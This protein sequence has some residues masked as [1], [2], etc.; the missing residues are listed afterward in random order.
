MSMRKAISFKGVIVGAIVDVVGTHIALYA[1]LA[2][3]IIRHQL[4]TLPPAEQNGELQHLYGDPVVGTVNAAIGFGFSIVGGYLA[5]RIAGHHQ[6]LNGALSAF[7][8][9]A[10]SVY[11]M[12]SL[13]IGWVI[14]GLLGSPALGFLGGYLSLWQTRRRLRTATPGQPE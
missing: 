5:A 7:L 13:S 6:R 4:Y 8:C 14:E 3:L 2:Y 11:M 10:L 9:V 1:V 12:K